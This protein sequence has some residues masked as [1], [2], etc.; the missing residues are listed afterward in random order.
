MNC[1]FDYSDKP[2]P[3]FIRVNLYPSRLRIQKGHLQQGSCC[4]DFKH[5]KALEQ[6]CQGS[7]S[8]QPAVIYLRGA[9]PPDI[10]SLIVHMAPYGGC[11]HINRENKSLS[12]AES[13]SLSPHCTT[14]LF[15][16]LFESPWLCPNLVKLSR[17]QL[18]SVGV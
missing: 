4:Q 1:S 8:S 10:G 11:S 18:F 17:F 14:R 13:V 9:G 2:F 6:S 16:K 15:R 5:W 12:F 7:H 3:Q